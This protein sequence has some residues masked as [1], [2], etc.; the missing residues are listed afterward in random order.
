MLRLRSVGNSLPE[1]FIVDPSAEFQPG[2]IGELTSIG[3]QI[4]MTVSN[5]T[6]PFGVIDDINTSAFTNVSWNETV[7][8]PAQGIPGPGGTIVSAVDIMKELRRPNILATS[9]NSTVK[10]VLNP[11]NGVVTFL[12]GTPLNIDLSGTGTPNG[13]KAIVN[14]TYQIPNIPGDSSVAGSLRVTIWYQRM[15][16][17]TSIFETNQQYPLRANLFVS[18]RGMLTTRKPSAIHP[19]VGMVTA[20]PSPLNA[21]LEALWY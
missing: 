13:I 15:I 20:P 2:Q 18:E 3:N 19:A 9:F 17:Q 21:M 16:F 14:Y 1:S 5:G 12:A 8:V 11:I 7:I 10:V 4:M 6:A